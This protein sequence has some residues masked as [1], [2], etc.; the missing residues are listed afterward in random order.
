MAG[1]PY[2]QRVWEQTLRL[3][4]WGRLGPQPHQTPRE[5]ACDLNERLPDLEGI[6]TL[7][8]AYNRSRFGQKPPDETQEADLRDAWKRVRGRLLRRVLFWR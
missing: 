5:Y 6:D 1:L 2:P 8:E 7:A 3:A 4:T